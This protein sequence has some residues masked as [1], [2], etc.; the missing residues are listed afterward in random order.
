MPRTIHFEGIPG[1]G[2]STAAQRLADLLISKGVDAAWW[3]EE[4]ADHPIMPK[5][6]RALSRNGNFPAICLNAWRSFLNA[7][8][9]NVAILEGYA[10][11]NTIRFLFEQQL[12][13]KRINT[14]FHHW[15]LLAP[16]ACITYF[17]VHDPCEHYATV[18]TERGDYW[19]RKL[20]AWVERTPIGAQRKL[21]GQRGFID[22]W[23]IY[24]DLC[25]DLLSS[26]TVQ[27]NL[28]PARS[29]NDRTLEE[30]AKQYEL[31]P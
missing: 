14:Y 10:F 19:A 11:Q 25:L 15:Q 12:P 23:S 26:A 1:A 20:F 16:D 21:Q 13:R 6:R 27:V 31:I 8:P 30:L 4:A 9:V 28:I 29:W 7:Q 3:L 18:F 17:S 5:Q 22:F 24:Q 2:K